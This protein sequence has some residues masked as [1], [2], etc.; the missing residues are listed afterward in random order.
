MVKKNSFLESIVMVA[1]V[2]VLIQT[3]LEDWAVISGWS[4]DVRRVMVF[5]G[6]VF[7]LFFTIEFLVRLYFSIYRGRAREYFFYE[8]G[9]IDFLASV[10]LLVLNSG[11]SSLALLAGGAA[12]FSLGGTMNI[13]KVVKAIRIARILRLLRM[14]KIFKQLKNAESVMAQRHVAK[15]ATLSVTVLVFGLFLFNLLAG[16]LGIPSAE[17]LFTGEK[18]TVLRNLPAGADDDIGALKEYASRE[19]SILIIRQRGEAVYTRYDNHYYDQWYGPWDYDYT[20]AEGWEI[21]FDR[22]TASAV[23]ARQNI[24]FFVIV[25][26]TVL[27]YMIF[28]SPHFALT[29]SDPIHVMRRGFNEQSYNLE[30]RI[31]GRYKND[32][33]YRLAASYNE[34]FLPLKDRNREDENSAGTLDLKIEDMGALFEE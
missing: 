16:P 3:F 14:L 7:D 1:I 29:V 10:P 25:I 15:I 31:P 21:F 26:L 27:A 17:D 9:W 18:E 23:S 13:L 32:D 24:M 5:S 8:K 22:T 19:K 11:P 33:I 12:G 6:L 28:Y 34:I 20:V 4:W 2:L 30:V